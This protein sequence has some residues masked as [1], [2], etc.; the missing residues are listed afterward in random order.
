MARPKKVI[1][2]K[3]LEHLAL[4][5]CTM[6]EMASCIGVSKDTLERRYAAFIKS[7]RE[8]GKMSLRRKMF[9][10]ALEGNERLLVWL[11]K[12][13]LDMRETPKEDLEIQANAIRVHKIEWGNQQESNGTT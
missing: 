7:A 9:T 6:E 2:E 1:D 3:L 8:K 5:H 10:M 12:Q 13:H 4:I 11:S